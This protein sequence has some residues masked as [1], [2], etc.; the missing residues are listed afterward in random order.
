MAVRDV[1]ARAE[2]A[3]ELHAVIGP[4]GAGKSTLRQLLS[5]RAQADRGP[6]R[7]SKAATSPARRPG[8]CRGSAS[9]ARSSAPTSSKSLSV[10]EN[11]RLGVQA[12]E[13]PGARHRCAAPHAR[14]C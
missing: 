12:V 1:S 5:G 4:N 6:H 13:A 10:L 11:V 8:E 3:G 7:T 2:R 14:P 9:R